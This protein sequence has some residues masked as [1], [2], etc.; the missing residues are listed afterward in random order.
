MAM[1]SRTTLRGESSKDISMLAAFSIARPTTE[2]LADRERAIEQKYFTDWVLAYQVSDRLSDGMFCT[3][4]GWFEADVRAGKL[5]AKLKAFQ[6]QM[7]FAWPVFVCS[8]GSYRRFLSLSWKADVNPFVRFNATDEYLLKWHY[9][10]W[11]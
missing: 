3:Y 7:S 2:V 11:N 6:R 1:P 8:M 4:S 5:W 10:Q 9:A